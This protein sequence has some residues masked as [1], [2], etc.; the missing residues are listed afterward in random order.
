MKSK[1]SYFRL[2]SKLYLATNSS[3]LHF[4]L[5]DEYVNFYHVYV[6]YSVTKVI[7]EYPD[8]TNYDYVFTLPNNNSYRAEFVQ[9]LKNTAFIPS[10]AT[11]GNGTYYFGVKLASLYINLFKCI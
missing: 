5:L 9:E 11:K 6:K 7:S 10:N 8:E 1:N 3:S 4:V 2:L